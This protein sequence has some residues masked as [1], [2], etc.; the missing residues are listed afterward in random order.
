MQLIEG[1]L[2]SRSNRRY[3]NPYELARGIDLYFAK[4]MESKDTKN[5]SEWRRIDYYKNPPTIP[6]LCLHLGFPTKAAL[7]NRLKDENEMVR[8]VVSSALLWIENFYI[9]QTL[10]PDAPKSYE[11]MLKAMGYKDQSSEQVT[12]TQSTS[13]QKD[14]APAGDENKVTFSVKLI[15]S[16]NSMSE[17]AVLQDL[18]ES[19]GDDQNLQEALQRQLATPMRTVTPEL[20]QLG[21]D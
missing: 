2:R 3:T 19:S 9:T 1:R 21:D 14:G 12:I 17:G 5:I 18:L 13:T 15:R 16:V 4:C 11:F 10:Q 6:G 8:E 7:V 20:Q